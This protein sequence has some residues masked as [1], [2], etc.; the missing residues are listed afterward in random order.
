MFPD[1]VFN[2]VTGLGATAGDAL[3][4][5]P[6]VRRLAFIGSAAMGRAILAA[7]S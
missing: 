4:R 6:D 1:G 2:V 5:H 3:V 7:A